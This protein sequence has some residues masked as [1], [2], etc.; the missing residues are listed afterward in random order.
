MACP[1]LTSPRQRYHAGRR[2]KR[3]EH[4][5]EAARGETMNLN[6]LNWMGEWMDQ[7][8]VIVKYDKQRARDILSGLGLPLWAEEVPGVRSVDSPCWMYSPGE[9]GTVGGC[10]GDGHYLCGECE[11][12]NPPES[13]DER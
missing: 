2:L 7:W 11:H 4:R 1:S 13:C 10:Q 3:I 12:R 9:A 8:D 6:W 5:L